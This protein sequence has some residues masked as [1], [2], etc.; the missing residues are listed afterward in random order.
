MASAGGVEHRRRL[1]TRRL[2]IVKR[3]LSYA[4]PGKKTNKFKGVCIEGKVQGFKGVF[5]AGKVQNL[6]LTVLNVDSSSQ[7][8]GINKREGWCPPQEVLSIDGVS[9]QGLLLPTKLKC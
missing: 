4:L 6:A 8:V 7:C 2:A 9:L 3:S 1:A 5:I